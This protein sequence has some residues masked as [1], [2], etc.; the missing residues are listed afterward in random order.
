MQCKKCNAVIKDDFKYCPYC[1]EILD[2]IESLKNDCK[3]NFIARN[4]NK[5]IELSTEVI[6]K[7]PSIENIYDFYLYRAMSNFQKKNYWSSIEDLTILIKLYP[8][9]AEYYK[10]RGNTYYLMKEDKNAIE[11]FKKYLEKEPN[12]E[13][14]RDR[15]Q[16]LLD[17]S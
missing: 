9:D 4:Y 7:Y 8:K 12:N 15:L 14:I 16:E 11:D 5:V 13:K 17:K 1:G 6:K 10:L 2:T 3:N